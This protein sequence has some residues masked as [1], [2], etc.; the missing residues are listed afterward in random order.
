SPEN[1][2]GSF[3]GP[4]TAH[5]ALI[6]S[7]NIPAVALA[8]RLTRPDFYEFLK[9]GGVARMA[10]RE[11]YGLALTLGG[12]EVTM[13]EMAR[14]YAMLANGGVLRGLRYR[15]DDA[16][17]PGVRL[18]SEESSFM[19]R[20]ILRDNPRP[21]EI[22]GQPARGLPVAWKTGTSWG[23]RDAWSAGLF[24][25]YVLV[26]WVG[27]FDGSGNPAFVGA[28]AAAPLFF[29]IVDAVQAQVPG[30]REPAW[31]VPPNLVRVTVCAASGDLPN[32]DCP[33][34]ASTW[35]IPGRSPIRVSTVHRR[36]LVNLRSGRQACAGDPAADVQA[37]VFEFWPS[38]LQRLFAQAGIPRRRPPAAG[39][40]GGA[41]AAGG[42]PP[43][44]TSPLGGA[45]YTLR[46]RRLGTESVPLSANADADVRTLYWFVDQSFVGA[47]GPGTALAW[48]PPSSGEFE[49]QAVDDHGRADSRRLRV[50][51]A[52]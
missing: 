17:E 7:R 26:V 23:F 1:F 10:S 37:Q 43:A 35:F 41:L 6:R 36:V 12:G 19:V 11:H 39:D 5:D 24:G 27:N 3:A 52:Q 8:A 15:A 34:T 18:L 4:I 28:Q 29:E 25:P 49:L 21:D 40:C 9:L 42:T 14:L 16:P 30:L 32:A 44:I 20:D 38:D 46:A 31:R 50:A 47:A 45:T 13:E 51:I 48:K 33:Q 22:A 2:D